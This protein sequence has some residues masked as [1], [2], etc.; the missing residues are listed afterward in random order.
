MSNICTEIKWQVFDLLELSVLHY[1]GKNEENPKK[2]WHQK[3]Q[4]VTKE[5]QKEECLL[6]ELGKR[7]V[8]DDLAF[9]SLIM[10]M[11]PCSSLCQYW[12]L[13]HTE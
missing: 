11:L 4:K 12:W 10:R 6:V 3:H 9:N 13:C 5:E 7:T 2:N 8:T 1:K